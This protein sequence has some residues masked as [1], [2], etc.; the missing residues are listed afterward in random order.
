MI[1]DV[2]D[3]PRWYHRVLD[4]L[5]QR[6]PVVWC[7]LFSR[8]FR[9]CGAEDELTPAPRRILAAPAEHRDQVTP[10]VRSRGADV[11]GHDFHQRARAALAEV[12]AGELRA[13]P[14]PARYGQQSVAGAPQEMPEEPPMGAPARSLLGGPA[15]VLVRMFCA[16][17]WPAA[18][19]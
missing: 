8:V 6:V 7:G 13:R 2:R 17:R 15:T 16:V 4:L 11:D 12:T 9:C 10:P 14:C 5:A 1:I 19:L 3:E 18:V